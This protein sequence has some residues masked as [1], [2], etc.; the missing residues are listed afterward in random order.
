M[1]KQAKSTKA[2]KAQSK[3]NTKGAVPVSVRTLCP[4]VKSD[5]VDPSESSSSSPPSAEALARLGLKIVADMCPHS[6]IPGHDFGT[7]AYDDQLNGVSAKTGVRRNLLDLAA[8]AA[9]HEVVTGEGFSVLPPADYLD[10]RLVDDI[11]AALDELEKEET[12]QRLLEQLQS[13][14]DEARQAYRDSGLIPG[15][16]YVVT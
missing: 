14:A 11:A 2:V 6:G 1:S 7:S 13:A 3:T 15:R 5:K 16:C 4:Q 10:K 9:W 12:S 8:R